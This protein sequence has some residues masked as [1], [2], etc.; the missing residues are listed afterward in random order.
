MKNN[1]YANLLK[2]YANRL[3][4]IKDGFTFEIVA[5]RYK[6]AIE[7]IDKKI[8]GVTLADKVI[9]AFVKMMIFATANMIHN[10]SVTVYEF[11]EID[12]R[13]VPALKNITER[14]ADHY[15]VTFW[16]T[17]SNKTQLPLSINMK[18]PEIT[19]DLKE[20]FSKDKKEIEDFVVNFCKIEN[21]KLN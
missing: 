18:L 2:T 15:G 5:E 17:V 13:F 9:S 11:D 19:E 8:N 3:T 16:Y 14:L 21:D 12:A 1:L 4:Q 10:Q 6:K 7:K 20:F